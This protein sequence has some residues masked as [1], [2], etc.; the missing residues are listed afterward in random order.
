MIDLKSLNVDLGKFR[1][2]DV[3]LNVGRG[4]YFILLGPTGAGKT[5]L[6]ETIAGLNLPRSGEVWLDGREVTCLAPEKRG[7][8]F[9]Y[10]DQA[11][12]PHLSVIDNITFG[13]RQRGKSKKEAEVEARG[14]IDLLGISHLLQRR[15]RTLSGGERQKV[16]LARALVIRPVV[17]LLDE[18]I[19]ALDPETRERMQRELRDIHD[20]LNLTVIHVTHDLE[21][22]AAIGDRIAVMNEGHIAQMGSPDDVFRRPNSEFVARFAMVRNIFVADIGDGAPGCGLARIGNTALKIATDLRGERH[23]ALRPE[24]I[25]ISREAP[26][27]GPE[28]SLRGSV[29]GISN[30]GSILYLTVNVPPEFVVLVTR[31]AF[32]ES[33]IGIGAKVCL[34]FEASAVHVS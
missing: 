22:A 34:N 10:Q 28:N 9:V 23:I 20:R 24:A 11:L 29:T 6:L 31:R 17:L 1:L 26:E 32:E 19:S 30:R 15:P 21:E 7:I 27:S 2:R 8:G 14:V 33:G 12:F 4:E 25:A 18:P 16:A 3:S 13:L 5:A